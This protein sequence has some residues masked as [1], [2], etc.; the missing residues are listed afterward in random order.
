MTRAAFRSASQGGFMLLEALI[1]ILIFS[2]GILSMVGLQSM[3]TR[4]ATDAKFRSTAGYLASKCMADI[5]VADRA[6]ISKTC[7]DDANL[8]DLPNG[9][10]TVVVAGDTLSGYT[11]TVTINWQ[12]PG[13]STTHQHE[14]VTIIHDRCD[15]TGCV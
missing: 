8:P 14:A 5:W 3:A 12:L 10:R 13:D 11:V 1:A 4:Y 6:K 7:V 9:K 15:T 2:V